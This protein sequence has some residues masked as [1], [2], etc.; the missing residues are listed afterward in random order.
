M[1]LS[2][3][4]IVVLKSGGPKMTIEK[5]QSDNY[6]CAYFKGPPSAQEL[7]TVCLQKAAV[8]LEA[9]KPKKRSASRP[10]VTG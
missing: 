7:V 3:G 5:V 6:V 4:D 2:A 10:I 9:D 8:I 1:S